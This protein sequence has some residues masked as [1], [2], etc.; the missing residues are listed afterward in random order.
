[1]TS[2]RPV[3]HDSAPPLETLLR[4]HAQSSMLM[5]VYLIG[6][7]ALLAAALLLQASSSH[8]STALRWLPSASGAM[9]M[10]WLVV[11][12][13]ILRRH[14]Q[15]MQTCS[16]AYDAEVQRIAQA[17]IQPAQKAQPLSGWAVIT[18]LIE[19]TTLAAQC[20]YCPPSLPISLVDSL[21]REQK[22]SVR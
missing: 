9:A 5:A 1:M 11:G 16:D 20:G 17:R 14:H 10:L 7:G 21:P 4:A 12:G 18:Q 19:Q 13:W 22:T 8:L 15:Y 3:P 6:G 2:A